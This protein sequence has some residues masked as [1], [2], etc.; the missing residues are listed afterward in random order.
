M[1]QISS[2]P[3]LSDRAKRSL[4]ML[5]DAVVLPLALWAAVALR[6]GDFN[7]DMTAFWWH[8]PIV[9]V[10]G[11]FTFR[12]LD[13]YRA[14]VRYIGPSSMLPVIQGVTA[15]AVAVSLT[16]YLTGTMTFPRSAPIIFWFIAILMI[17][18]GRI[19]VRAYFYGLFNNY[20]T[21][22]NVAIYGAGDSGAQLAIALLNGDEYMPVG[23][24]D[25]N[26]DLRR[27]TING[28]R[29]YDTNNLARLVEQLGIRRIL[30]ALPPMDDERRRAV[31]NRLSEL[32]V[33]INK[34]P[35]IHGLVSGE[36]RQPEIQ[37]IEIG[38]LLGREA[39]PPDEELLAGAIRDKN[40]LVTGA[41][42]TIGSEIA[43]K[44]LARK[45]ARL[46]LYDNS[47]YGLYKLEQELQGVLNHPEHSETSQPT[48]IVVLL[49][50]ILN[51]GHLLNV[52]NNFDIGTVYH[53]AAYKHVPLVEQNI[54]EGVRNNVV[55]TWQVANAVA[56]SRA[57][58]LVMISSDKAV[59]PTNVMGASKRLAE[60]I[61]QGFAEAAQDN[62]K[63]YCMVRFGNVLKSSGSVVPLF[64][65]QIRS[66]GPVTVTHPDTTRYFMTCEEASELVIQAGAMAVGGEIFVL[67]MGEPVFIREL[68]EKMIHLHGK[69]VGA[70]ND[71]N[72]EDA[73]EISFIGLRP[74]E[75]LTEE[76]VIGENITGTRHSKIMQAREAGIDWQALEELCETLQ[77]A[78]KQADYDTVKNQLET[79]VTGYQM[80]DEAFDPGFAIAKSRTETI[81]PSGDQLH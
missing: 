54:I 23:F 71:S 17:G 81:K 9:A 61:I 57:T 40:I 43:R 2:Q 51:P 53:A 6:Y 27:N 56:E 55:G 5:A 64:E 79:Y 39:V 52:I 70:N 16:S 50:S 22:E 12:K 72:P 35:G 11:V 41:A 36:H 48:E 68:A 46:V 15:A 33:H 18:G 1:T 76:L 44:I 45:P 4:L 80:Q 67:D 74:G 62:G 14:I 31:L 37:E 65:K 77:T 10:I 38:D 34:I 25:D 19:V 30:L 60:L 78:C 42:G 32:P 73:I 8:F 66:G 24:I 13:L 69:S 59:R 29:V 28:I 58:E 47:E 7:M 3:Q 63:R 21:R 26:R 75:K 20:L 49:G